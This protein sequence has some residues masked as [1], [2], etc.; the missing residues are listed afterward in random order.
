MRSSQPK[1]LEAS[2]P[3]VAASARLPWVRPPPPVQPR[4]G[5][6]PSDP[7]VTMHSSAAQAWESHNPF[8]VDGHGGPLTQR[9]L[10]VEP[11]LGWGPQ[12]PWAWTV[13]LRPTGQT[14]GLRNVAVRRSGLR[15]SAMRNLAVRRTVRRTAPCASARAASIRR[16]FPQLTPLAPSRTFGR[17]D[18]NHMMPICRDPGQVRRDHVRGRTRPAPPAFAGRRWFVARA[19]WSARLLATPRPRGDRTLQIHPPQDSA[20]HSPC[21]ATGQRPDFGGPVTCLNEPR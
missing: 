4:S 17:V 5:L 21:P 6:W 9:R 16:P 1:G 2:S 3:T 12:A 18:V 13:Q 14:P 11:T 19:P 15:S 20:H 8:R 7:R 10:V